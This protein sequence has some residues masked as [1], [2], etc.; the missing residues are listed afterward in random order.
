MGFGE[1]LRHWRERRKVSLSGLAQA[2]HYSKGYLSRVERR[3]RK[4]E[5]LLAELADDTLG[6]DGKLVG[7]WVM[8]FGPEPMLGPSAGGEATKRRTFLKSA[9]TAV[10]VPGLAEPNPH[11]DA[12]A[13]LRDALVPD[14]P[15]K[16]EDISL[17]AFGRAVTRARRDFTAARYA[18]LADDLADLVPVARAATD[19]AGI[20]LAAQV[21]HLAARTLIKLS[22][23]PYAWVAAHQAEQAA[24]ASGDLRAIAEARRDM[25]SLFHRAAGYGKARDLTAKAADILR[26][27]LPKA[28]PSAWGAYGT[29]MSTGAIAAA[30]LEDRHTALSMLGEADEASHRSPKLVLSAGHVVT[31]RIGVSIILGDAGT[32]IDHARRIVPE[33]I[34]TVE[35]RASYFTGIAEAYTLWGKTDRAVRALLIAEKIAPTEMRRAGPRRVIED[36]LHRDPHSNLSGLRALARRMSVTL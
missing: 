22:A 29:L 36:L 30:R 23:P 19:P 31:Y 3:Q 21:Y 26:P 33:E 12:V 14:S 6:A 8:E 16:A 11:V 10:V 13:R 20:A 34:P 35:R 25:V 5:R 24:R 7:A 4:P 28:S 15:T 32:A 1:Q 27:A 2:T 17:P 18:G 9:S